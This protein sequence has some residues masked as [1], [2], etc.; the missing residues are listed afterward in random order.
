MRAA[1]TGLAAMNW[2]TPRAR[3]PSGPLIL[4]VPLGLRR[5]DVLPA[6]LVAVG[7]PGGYAHVGRGCAVAGRGRH[8]RHAGRCRH[9]RAPPPAVRGAGT[10]HTST[11]EPAEYTDLPDG[12]RDSP[13]WQAARELDARAQDAQGRLALGCCLFWLNDGGYLLTAPPPMGDVCGSA[14]EMTIYTAEHLITIE[15][16]NLHMLA[17]AMKLQRVDS[18]AASSA[19]E[20]SEEAG[21]WTI[22]SI[23]AAAR[24]DE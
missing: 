11:F 20:H 1:A 3:L 22:S 5:R 6:V 13:E 19:T 15:G 21:E 10:G 24:S 7:S 17:W 8:R 23:T 14:T 2:L 4:V 12:R 9:G 18:L 16:E